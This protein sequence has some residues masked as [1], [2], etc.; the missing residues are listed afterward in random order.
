MDSVV[1][2]SVFDVE[3][4]SALVRAGVAAAGGEAAPEDSVGPDAETTA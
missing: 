2:P 4:V 3:V 1:L